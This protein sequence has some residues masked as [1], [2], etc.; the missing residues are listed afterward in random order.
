MRFKKV[1]QNTILH[2]RKA[3]CVCGHAF[4]S[5][6]KAQKNVD[7]DR[8]LAKKRRRAFESEQDTVVRKEQERVRKAS[9]RASETCEQTLE[10]QEHNRT[11]MASMRAS[12]TCEQCR[13]KS[14]LEY[15]KRV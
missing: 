14:R 4:A 2:A 7:N 6:R 5:K 9:M 13:D 12:E 8:L 1:C 15:V 11:H 10:R 3:V